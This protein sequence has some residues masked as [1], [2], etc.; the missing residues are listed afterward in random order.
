MNKRKLNKAIRDTKAFKEYLDIQ[1]SVKAIE[2]TDIIISV[3]GSEPS[4]GCE[5]K[6]KIFKNSER[7]S[8]QHP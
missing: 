1:A 6:I 4:D 5:T 7:K 2:N 3:N 8:R